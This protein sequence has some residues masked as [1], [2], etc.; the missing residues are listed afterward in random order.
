M[1][2]QP[3]AL[4][5]THRAWL[6]AI[7]CALTFPLSG[8]AAA[9]SFSLFEW[10]LAINSDVTSAPVTDFS[11]FDTATG[12]G[13]IAMTF[14]AAGSYNVRGFFDHEID[15]A[16]N[17]FFNEYGAARGTLASGASWEIDE[18]GYV[19]GDIYD[20]VAAGTLDNS[21]GV[22]DTA[23]DDVSMALGWNFTLLDAKV[24]SVQFNVGP[25]APGSGFYLQQT[26]PDSIASIYLWSTLA[27]RDAEPHSVPEPASLVLLGLGLAA[28]AGARGRAA[29]T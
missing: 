12:I 3:N 29:H 27:I 9:A 28:W 6:G 24:A 16:T 10:A 2:Q 4:R 13:T 11:A 26:D 22:P 18:P 7:A 8:P 15:E 25:T 20:N 21:N 5:R 14:S 19:F 1:M 23:P 17:T